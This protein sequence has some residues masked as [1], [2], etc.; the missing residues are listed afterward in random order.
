MNDT[1]TN[2]EEETNEEISSSTQPTVTNVSSENTAPEVLDDMVPD[3]I[4]EDMI[5]NGDMDMINDAELIDIPESDSNVEQY[6]MSEREDSSKVTNM[7]N[8]KETEDETSDDDD[9]I[10]NRSAFDLNPSSPKASLP[11]DANTE[12]NTK[13]DEILEDVTHQN[14]NVQGD[15]A[16]A[17]TKVMD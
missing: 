11:A 1:A 4:F 14:N 12:L 3:D 2:V 8:E 9:E 5:T 7:I 15:A 17:S 16:I 13:Q 10:L 6:N